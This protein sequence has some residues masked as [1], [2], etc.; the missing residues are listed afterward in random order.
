MGRYRCDRD[1]GEYT[2]EH[3]FLHIIKQSTQYFIRITVRPPRDTPHLPS[4]RHDEPIQLTSDPYEFMEA[5]LLTD[6][7][8]EPALGLTTSRPGPES[9]YMRS[10]LPGGADVALPLSDA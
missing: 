10:S 6:M 9:I 4:F 5:E 7:I 8:S 1:Q 3:G 2:F